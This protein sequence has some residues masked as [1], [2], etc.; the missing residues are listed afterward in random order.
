MLGVALALLL[1]GAERLKL[2]YDL[3]DLLLVGDDNGYAP[4]LAVPE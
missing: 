2:V 3:S 1:L 4:L